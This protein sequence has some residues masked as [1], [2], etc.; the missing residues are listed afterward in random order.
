M[1]RPPLHRVL[2]SAGGAARLEHALCRQSGG[3]MLWLPC[4]LCKYLQGLPK[5]M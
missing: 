2:V 3:D 5:A 1:L 4:R